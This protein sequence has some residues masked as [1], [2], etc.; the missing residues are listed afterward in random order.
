MTTGG[1]I[2]LDWSDA[3]AEFAR[4]IRALFERELTPELRAGTAGMTSV[5]ADHDV[6]MAL[7]AKLHARGLAAP[8]W[9][10]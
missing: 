2:N 6:S 3:E 5:Y 1:M 8:H 7:Q 4:E 10:P 9:L